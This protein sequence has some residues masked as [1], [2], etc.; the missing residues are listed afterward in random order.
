MRYFSLTSRFFCAAVVLGFSAH[1][2]TAKTIQG[3]ANEPVIA[4]TTWY[5]SSCTASAGLGSY[6]LNVAPSYG[7]VSIDD[8]SGPLPGCPAGSP[9]LPAVQAS[10]TWTDTTTTAASDFFELYY[11]LN[12]EVAGVYDVT[13]TLNGTGGTC[14]SVE[15]APNSVSDAK[16]MANGA[17][18]IAKSG[19]ST[20]GSAL[21]ANA[22]TCTPPP[23]PYDCST[24]FSVVPNNFVITPRHTLI[25]KFSYGFKPRFAA[26][27]YVYS[28]NYIGEPLLGFD[29]PPWA[30]FINAVKNGGVIQKKGSPDAN[31]LYLQD[32]NKWTGYGVYGDEGVHE[33][34]ASPD[35]EGTRYPDP[36]G[37][38]FV[39]AGLYDSPWIHVALRDNDG[40]YLREIHY[41]KGFRT[42]I[43]CN[44]PS[45]PTFHPLATVDWQVNYYG[46][47]EVPTFFSFPD[48][49]FTIFEQTGTDVQAGPVV[50]NRTEQPVTTGPTAGD[51]IGYVPFP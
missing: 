20:S 24:G 32:L 3:I 17:F 2:A 45:D 28:G 34:Q 27:E 37:S 26:Y 50:E 18:V 51:V 6:S 1:S 33:Y 46:T 39:N 13:V 40:R 23:P 14:P 48:Y 29:P 8:V 30:I 31:I 10:Y 36:Q 12:G 35:I 42:Y 38:Q 11:M 5:Y 25:G 22:A 19:A 47:V 9:S 21:T 41:T 16:K 4:E 7:S 15:M 44:T 43:G 49:S